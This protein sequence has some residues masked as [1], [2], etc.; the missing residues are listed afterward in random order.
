MANQ[1]TDLK[2]TI[3][4]SGAAGNKARQQLRELIDR[5]DKVLG[6]ME[7]IGD[8]NQ[9]IKRIKEIQDK[10]RDQYEVL[11]A[12]RIELEKIF[13]KQFDEGDAPKEKKP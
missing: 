1:K 5:L 7:K 10:N 13:W 9:L 6:A 3:E 4:L 8:L 11:K 12:L 2:K